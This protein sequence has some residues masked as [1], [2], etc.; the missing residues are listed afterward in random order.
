M[1]KEGVCREGELRR[2]E[3]KR[4]AREDED[5]IAQLDDGETPQVLPVDGMTADA[6]EGEGRGEAVDEDEEGL[7]ADDGVDEAREQF[8][9]E[10]G[11]LLDKLGKVV[12]P[13]CCFRGCE[14]LMRILFSGAK[15][16]WAG[17]GEG[18]KGKG[19]NYR[20]RE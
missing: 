12:E 17:V 6:E 2:R 5:G 3:K 10:D 9:G 8:L 18:G 15:I 1:E 13:G 11:V 16:H 7:E 19:D 4:T 14:K 20:L